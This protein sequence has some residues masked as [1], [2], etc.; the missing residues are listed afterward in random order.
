M[1]ILGITNRTENW[2]T[3]E[4]FAPFFEC[5]SART[6]LAKRLLE[7]LGKSHEVQ[8]RTVKIELFWWFFC[9]VAYRP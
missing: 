5:D 3:A 1:G 6:R 8:P 4:S 2:K 7:P 9:V